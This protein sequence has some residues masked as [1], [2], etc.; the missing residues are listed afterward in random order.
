M[1]VT[2]FQVAI[3]S[4]SFL[5]GV[6]VDGSGIASAMLLGAAFVAGA[7]AVA[8]LLGRADRA[9]QSAAARA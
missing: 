4:G 5:G 7:T 3:A 9:P 1:L 8:A 2:A 6:V